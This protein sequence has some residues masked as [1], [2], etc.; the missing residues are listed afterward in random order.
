M[1][2]ATYSCAGLGTE[3]QAPWGYYQPLEAGTLDYAGKLVLYTLGSAC[4]ETSCCGKGSWS[5]ARVEGYIV[6][7]A[8]PWQLGSSGPTEV[9]TVENVQDR[10]AI[11]MLLGEEHPG[12]RVEFR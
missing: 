12:I 6:T 9:D 3:V 11:T 4:V 10:V 8:Q 1:A 2:K 7:G 5:Y